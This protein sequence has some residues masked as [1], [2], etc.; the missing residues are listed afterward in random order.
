M[1]K[2]NIP[3]FPQSVK[4]QSPVKSNT[5][6]VTLGYSTSGSAH[7]AAGVQGPYHGS[8]P[9][10]NVTPP[11]G[12]VTLPVQIQCDRRIPSRMSERVQMVFQRLPGPAGAGS[13]EGAGDVA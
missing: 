8:A 2:K 6:E 9:K 1:G 11:T 10:N 4:P 7:I 5:V 3:T 12:T 13:E